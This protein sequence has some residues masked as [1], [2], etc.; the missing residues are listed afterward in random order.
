MDLTI[1]QLK[2]QAFRPPN[3]AG[4]GYIKL[5]VLI[6]GEFF[7]YRFYSEIAH[8]RTN[9]QVHTH[10]YDFRSK[11]IKGTLRNIIY[12]VIPT[13]EPSDFYL[14]EGIC[15]SNEFENHITVNQNVIVTEK[16]QFTTSVGEE[17]VLENHV[18]H[19]IRFDTPSVITLL[20]PIVADM[21][22]RQEK[23]CCQYVID[24]NIGPVDPW[25]IELTVQECW[26]IIRECLEL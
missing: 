8:P 10:T 24:R 21:S 22:K 4:S 9:D 2:R 14:T 25:G 26:E 5:P 6:D 1:D 3:R 7:A 16:E 23:G 18:F 20:Q 13:D 17:Y 19:R 11:T 12:D 15:R